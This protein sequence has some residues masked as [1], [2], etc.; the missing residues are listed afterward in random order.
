MRTESWHARGYD[1]GANFTI[2]FCGG[3]VEDLEGGWEVAGGADVRPGV[4]GVEKREWR[5]VS[6]FYVR[7]G[8]VFSVG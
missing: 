4:V 1:Y 5:D 8:R 7:E 3:V 6:A 2:N